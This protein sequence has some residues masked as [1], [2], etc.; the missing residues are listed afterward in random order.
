MVGSPVTNRVGHVRR[1]GPN[2]LLLCA[3]F[4]FL[5]IGAAAAAGTASSPTKIV[6]DRLTTTGSG[7]DQTGHFA[8]HLESPNE[9]CLRGRTVKLFLRNGNTGESKLADTDTTGKH[10]GWSLDGNL[11]T[12]DR[13]KVK[14]TRER[15]GPRGNRQ[16]CETDSLSRF[17]A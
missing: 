13:A 3:V 2:V 1:L 16:I 7:P 17:F 5:A 10:G 12:I 15:I 14:V 8:G 6:L 11:F 4:V 9:K